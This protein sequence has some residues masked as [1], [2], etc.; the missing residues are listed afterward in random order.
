MN[1]N[2]VEEKSI[3]ENNI[4]I[5]K[6]YFPNAIRLND[7]GRYNIDTQAL[8][9]AIDPSK[10]KIDEDGYSLNWVGKKEAYSSAYSKNLKILKPLKD[11]SKEWEDTENILIKG[12]NID[13][14]KILRNNY[15]EKIKMIYIDPP[16]NTKNDNFI[17]KDNFTNSELETLE[18]LGYDS[19]EKIDYIK[20]IYGAKTHS[21][22][23]SFMFPRLLLAKDLL[24]DD[25][26]IFI[27][28][29]DNEV[30][31]LK[32]LCDEVF[33]EGNFVG[34]L[35][36][37]TRTS[38]NHDEVG[39]NIQHENCLIYTKNKSLVNIKGKEKTFK[40]YKNPD[41]DPNGNWISADPSAN[42]DKRTKI[43][44]FEIINPYT[45]KIDKPPVGNHWRF[46]EE[47]FEE[48]LK[49]GKIFYKKEH[50][51]NERGFVLKRYKKD[52]RSKFHL[53][54]SLE[55]ATNEY[56]NQVGTRERNTIFDKDI[57]DYPKPNKFLISL[58]HSSTSRSDIILDFF[59]GSATTGDAVMQLNAEDGGDRKYILVQIPQEIDSK[60]QKTAYEFVKND[61]QKEPNIF[62]ITAER[63]RRAGEKIKSESKK[64]IDIGF[65][66]FEVVEDS[67]QAIYQKSLLE[68]NQEDLNLFDNQNEDIETVLYNMLIAE[69]LPLSSKIE[70]VIKDRF[71]L[72]D[73]I[74]FILHNFE[75]KEV[76]KYVKDLEYLTIYSPNIDDDKFTLELQSFVESLGL[77]RNKI[78]FRG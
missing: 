13:A 37:K 2:I 54:N 72:V 36:R 1:K 30:A 60:K 9:L 70:E 4:E 56:L 67:K 6:R 39:F 44:N 19:K 55:C 15:Y 41:N 12:D 47:S 75:F 32:L 69:N 11:E 77:K 43:N 23:L 74:G 53:L 28:I 63:L 46:N 48:M 10:A 35:I 38:T 18:E 29:D 26:V 42:L 25:G 8:Q 52:I 62:E 61:L 7:D 66:I 20:N 31:N 76:E 17:Y 45:G 5:L 71:Y 34:D 50:K 58:I 33:G 78:R 24:K 65:R 40:E 14:L 73:N 49:S 21:G 16:Y 51:E 22:W 57:F 64:E 68:V 59:A 3:N 27:S